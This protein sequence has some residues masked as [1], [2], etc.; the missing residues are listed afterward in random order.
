MIRIR[1]MEPRDTCTAA[2]I[3]KGNFS[4]PWSRESFDSS[5]FRKDTLYLAAE[6]D[7][8]L[9]GY[10]GMWISLDE[11]EITNV[12]VAQCEQGKGIGR[13]LLEQLLTEAEQAGVASCFLEVRKSNVRALAL[14]ESMGFQRVGTRRNFYE[15]PVEDG[16]VMIRR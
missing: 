8:R 13:M 4:R 14:Y 11:G 1:R 5:A 12:S 7:G 15:A 6:K 16:I 10:A 3:E 9:V 2:D